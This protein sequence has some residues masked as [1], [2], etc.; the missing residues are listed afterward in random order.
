MVTFA[1][2]QQFV[3][4]AGRSVMTPVGLELRRA[5]ELVRG[6]AELKAVGQELRR[7]ADQMQAIRDLRPVGRWP[8]L[9]RVTDDRS[10]P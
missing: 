1:S 5:A 7:F 4:G 2:P 9:H 10:T 8:Q 6:I 3:R